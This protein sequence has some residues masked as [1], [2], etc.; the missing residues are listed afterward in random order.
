ML[1]PLTVAHAPAM[2]SLLSDLALY[3]PPS[4]EHLQRVYAQ[5]ETRRSPDGTEEWL[6][7]IVL[8]DG[9][10]I[11][12]VQATIYTDRSANVAYVFGRSHWGHGY[13]IEAVTAML[14][15]LDGCKFFATVDA[16]NA[17]SIRLLERLGFRHVEGERYER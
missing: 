4:L 9:E 10:V 6:N 3:A 1:E 8:R 11:G 17:R 15:Q 14:A 13:A 2:F 7:W 5:L 16:G 12:F